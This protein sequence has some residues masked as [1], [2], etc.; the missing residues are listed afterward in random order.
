M[1]WCA[2]CRRNVSATTEN[3]HRKHAKR[4]RLVAAAVQAFRLSEKL[5]TAKKSKPKR[6]LSHADPP[7]P[8]FDIEMEDY[9]ES[10][11]MVDDGAP[12]TYIE[13]HPGLQNTQVAIWPNGVR[14]YRAY[15]EDADSDN[16]GSI[17][18]GGDGSEGF[19]DEDGEDTVDVTNYAEGLSAWDQL[20]VEFEQEAA[21]SGEY[22]TTYPFD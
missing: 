2:H 9:F 14:P 13:P 16:D 1:P 8:T 22:S 5:P 7:A 11:E 4:P 21:A 10:D 20:G 3:L 18:D 19:D 12:A 17:S 6:P 15:V